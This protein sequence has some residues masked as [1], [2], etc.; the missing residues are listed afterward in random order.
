MSFEC[1]RITFGIVD[2]SSKYKVPAS[3]SPDRTSVSGTDSVPSNAMEE[4][5]A[6][7]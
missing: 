3:N 4:S 5:W 6:T 2:S 7:L 1:Q